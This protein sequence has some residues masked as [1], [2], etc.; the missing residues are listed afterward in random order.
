V[1]V[2][3]E[4]TD[5]VTTGQRLKQGDGLAPLLFNVASEF[6]LKRLSIDLKGTIEYRSTQVLAY[7]DG[8]AIISQSLSHATEI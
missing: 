5:S 6:I 2:Q 3:S 1:R 7:A 4:L 8:I